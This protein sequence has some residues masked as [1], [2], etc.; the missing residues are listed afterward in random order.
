VD[1]FDEDRELSLVPGSVAGLRWWGLQL[2]ADEDVSLRGAFGCL[3]TSEDGGGERVARCHRRLRV[4]PFPQP[5]LTT[6]TTPEDRLRVPHAVPARDCGCGFWA[7]WDA[8]RSSTWEAQEVGGVIEGYGRVLLGTRG[9]RSERARLR[10]LYLPKLS[11]CLTAPVHL[12]A[13]GP[14]HPRGTYRLEVPE[15]LSDLGL[16]VPVGLCSGLPESLIPASGTQ[17]RVYASDEAMARVRKLLERR[18]EVPVYGDLSELLMSFP[19]TQEYKPE[20]GETPGSFPGT[21]SGK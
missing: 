4:L 10:G 17:Q 8:E 21:W 7:Y 3:W 9:F 2:E 20:C 13:A 14:E 15:A 5:R 6:R 18:F 12:E 19:T 16:R 1:G 11:A